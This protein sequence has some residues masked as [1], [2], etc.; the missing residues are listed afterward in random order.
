MKTIQLVAFDLDG[1]LLDSRSQLPADVRSALLN[2]QSG[3]VFITLIT[4]RSHTGTVPFVEELE[5]GIPF[6]LVHGAWVTDNRGTDIMKR[7]IP[8][9]GITEAIELAHQFGCVPLIVSDRAKGN[10]VICEEDADSEIVRFIL[11]DQMTVNQF[12]P[13][14]I[15][16]IPR[17]ELNVASYVTYVIG[18]SSQ[19]DLLAQSIE[20]VPVKLYQWMRTPVHTFQKDHD[21][22]RTHEVAMLYPQG[23]DKA[24]ALRSIADCLNVAMDEVLAFGDW[25]NDI[26]MLQASGA[27]VLMGNAPSSVVEQLQHPQLLHT[28]SN[29][30]G[31]ILNALAKFDLV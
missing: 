7:I 20:G 29:D 30:S 15:E 6:G 10:L 26:P 18:P 21:I 23:A 24:M 9:V 5:I 3:G 28:T 27:A 11:D 31:G 16:I 2:L 13:E 1:T 8:P 17:Q 22:R 4:G 12:R 25:H 19:I 14:E